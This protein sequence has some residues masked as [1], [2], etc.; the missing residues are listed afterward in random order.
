M[1]Y[2]HTRITTEYLN[3]LQALALANKRSMMRELE[4]L[5]DTASATL[6]PQRTRPAASDDAKLT[7]STETGEKQP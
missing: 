3:K 5:I 6:S 7:P 2:T 4:L 1:T